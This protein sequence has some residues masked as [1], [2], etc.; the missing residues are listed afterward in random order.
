MPRE[1]GGFILHSYAELYDEAKKLPKKTAEQYRIYFSELDPLFAKRPDLFQNIYIASKSTVSF[2]TSNIGNCG[3]ICV[4]NI[5]FGNLLQLRYANENGQATSYPKE[6]ETA[7]GTV[8]NS[9]V[10]L[11]NTAASFV[12][13]HLKEKDIEALIKT[14]LGKISAYNSIVVS[15]SVNRASG[16]RYGGEKPVLRNDTATFMAYLEKSKIGYLVKSPI[17]L[18]PAHNSG[19]DLSIIRHWIYY[20]PGSVV[21]KAGKYLGSGEP[22]PEDPQEIIDNLPKY[23]LANNA[24]KAGSYSADFF[25]NAFRNWSKGSPLEKIDKRKKV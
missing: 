17:S 15:D 8:W 5:T 21:C 7:F 14:F 13:S 6:W 12:H 22:I 1:A 16:Y 18:N 25:V 2:S 23:R 19:G 20:P 3:T 4:T 9:L 24:I 10:Y 11:A